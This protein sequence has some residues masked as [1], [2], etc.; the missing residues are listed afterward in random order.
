MSLLTLFLFLFQVCN[1]YSVQALSV[2]RDTTD[3]SS[4]LE[5]LDFSQNPHTINSASEFQ[6]EFE[7]PYERQRI[8]LN[9][10]PSR[11]VVHRLATIQHITSNEKHDISSS[12]P[13]LYKG[14]A[15]VNDVEKQTQRRVGWARIMLRHRQGRH[16]IEGTFTNDGAYHHISLD[17]D[18]LRT[19]QLRDSRLAKRSQQL[20]VWKES[21]NEYDSTPMKRSPSDESACQAQRPDAEPEAKDAPH[22]PLLARQSVNDWFDPREHIGSTE[23]CPSSRR[24]ALIGVAA[25]CSYTAEFGSMRDARDNI[26]SQI[27]TASQVYEDSL[28]IALAIQN[29][30]MADPSCPTEAPSSMPWNLGCTANANMNDR[31]NL[32]TQWRSRLRDDNAVWS[33]FTT[34]RSGSTVGIAWIGSLCNRSRAAWRGGGTASANVVV[35]TASEWQVFAHEVAHNFGASH[36]CTSGDC[37]TS[38]FSRSDDCCPRSETTC[39]ARNQYLMNPQSSP[40]LEEFSPCTIGTICTGIGEEHIDTSCL[41]SEDD[42]PDVNDSQCGN[43]IVEPGESC[44]CGGEGGCP[45]DSCCNPSTCQLRSGAECDPS[46]DGCCTDECRVARSGLVCRESTAD[47]DPEEVCDGSSSQCP[48]DEQNCTDDEDSRGSGTSSGSWFSRNR[49]AVIAT[50]AS[51]KDKKKEGSSTSKWEYK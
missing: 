3:R 20:I 39:D 38:G 17:S 29:L 34:C 13:L 36:D 35:R 43:G 25:D 44:D 48:I 5:K 49:T 10:Q 24:V 6:V 31:L 45:D 28:N 22:R 51:E 8:T 27:N 14:V 26:I 23:G 21:N 18:Y 40:G 16:I 46:T 37:G 47:C 19:R 42:V 33:L 4:T 50:S 7:V 12:S 30:T 15:F 9:L 1:L 41:V 32:F 2:A 11:H